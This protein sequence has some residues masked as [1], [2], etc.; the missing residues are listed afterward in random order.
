M[1]I[2]ATCKLLHKGQGKGI[3]SDPLKF[4]HLILCQTSL[5]C[6]E[7]DLRK[8]ENQVGSQFDTMLAGGILLTILLVDYVVVD[9]STWRGTISGTA[10]ESV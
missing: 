3:W 7:T 9:F 6:I 2:T 10:M 5:E 1:A 8:L 4:Y